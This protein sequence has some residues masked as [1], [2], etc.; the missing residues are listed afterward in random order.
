M[1]SNI[2]VVELCGLTRTLVPAAVVGV[3]V[4]TFT[5]S[6]VAGWLAAVLAAGIVYALMRSAGDRRS[7]GAAVEQQAAADTDRPEPV[8]TLDELVGDDRRELVDH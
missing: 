7:C 2:D 6:E 3:L 4:S 1:P 5:A 8:F